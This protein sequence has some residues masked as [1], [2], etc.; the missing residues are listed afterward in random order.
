MLTFSSGKSYIGMTH[1]SAKI[2]YK[3]HKH[4]SENGGK[5]A[6]HRAWRK[7]GAPKLKLLSQ[8][9]S[10]TIKREEKK[11]VKLHNT[12]TP[13]GYNMTPGGET[14]PMSV[15][16]LKARIIKALTG[17]IRTAEHKA[18]ISKALIGRSLPKKTRK[19]M[20]K[21]QTGRKLSSAHIANI[22]IGLKRNKRWVDRCRNICVKMTK[23]QKGKPLSALH[24]KKISEGLKRHHAL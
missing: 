7:Y 21:W 22:S 11:A 10:K 23:M 2:R 16:E 3:A 17:R 8:H 5:L 19:K 9:G 13:S 20:S 14:V 12:M 15:P 1:G 6:I 24:K 18:N 4:A